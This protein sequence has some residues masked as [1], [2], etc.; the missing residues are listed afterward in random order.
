[1]IG[2]ILAIAFGAYYY[3]EGENE[4][5]LRNTLLADATER[6]IETTMSLGTHITS[7]ID[8]LV[9]KLQILAS[10]S[11]IQRGALASE[12]TTQLMKASDADIRQI[13]VINSIALLDANNI[14]VNNSLEEFRGF[15][16]MDRS[17][18][19]FVIETRK[20][21]QPFVSSAF[22]GVSGTFGLS[23][24][25][26]IINQ[27]SGNYIG[28]LVAGLPTTEFFERYG[29]VLDV[30]SSSIV[31]VDRNGAIISTAI[32]ELQG[33]DFF[34][35]TVQDF[36]G[37]SE[38]INQLYRNVM[39]GNSDSA[40]F[41]ATLG[42]RFSSGHPVKVNGEQIM[43]V[44]V[45]TPTAAI[46]AN[47]DERLAIGRL[48]VSAL[49]AA[50]SIALIAL[51]IFI[52]KWNRTLD[53]R[54]NEQTSELRQANE[55]LRQHDRM[56]RE[57]INIAAH[58][59]RTPIQPLIGIADILDQT[60]EK[61]GSIELERPEFEMLK[62]NA[63]RL[64]RLSSDILQVS[65]IESQSLTLDKEKVRLTEKISNV[66]TDVRSTIPKE[67]NVKIVVE[68]FQTD[69]AVMADKAKLFEVLSNLLRNAIKFTKSGTITISVR[70]RHD[71]QDFVEISIKDTG[72]G[73]D[74]Q[75]MPRLFTKF[76]SKSDQG[77]GLGL[78]ISKSI[79]EAHGGKIWAENNKNGG[80]TFTFT[81]PLDANMANTPAERATKE[82]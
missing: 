19:E 61:T 25:V 42:E 69:L 47:V 68:S 39:S 78:F 40:L 20:S 15:I 32:P 23:V 48:Q 71:N 77:T 54:V 36:S 82:T 66:V 45:T 17:D 80:A 50:I 59:L 3:L 12:K 33:Q 10:Q 21:M 67:S 8:R 44:F 30:D 43:S 5:E 70:L 9:T 38:V 55:Q 58:E 29:N 62:R 11:E 46:Y 56:Q 75:L 73:I 2:T 81:L 27:D 16:G 26:P 14:H 31:A 74:E 35:E 13:T 1:M 57:F 22:T 63:R 41:T 6:Q 51:I 34:G 79:V 37:R 76:A 72:T 49:L 4:K 52:I 28:I 24:S 64:E 18:T 53:T 65:R 7:D 60:F